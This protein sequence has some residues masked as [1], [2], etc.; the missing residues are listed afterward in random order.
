MAKPIPEATGATIY[1][2]TGAFTWKSNTAL[3]VIGVAG[4]TL[5]VTG[6]LAL[7][8]LSW[9]QIGSP[10]G[11]YALIAGGGALLAVDLVV[12]SVLAGKHFWSRFKLNE[13]LEQDKDYGRPPQLDGKGWWERQFT[14]RKA[15]EKTYT[16]REFRTYND[17][18][19]F[20]R[21]VVLHMDQKQRSIHLFLD[22]KLHE[23]YVKQLK[24]RGF[25][26]KSY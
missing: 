20:S 16:V 26:E 25:S 12:L 3:A 8:H 1:Y 18:I 22:A 13:W 15:D 21:S 19:L 11:T 2:K 5:L 17:G 14:S 24:T 4:I 9:L 23:A 7:Q 10:T 6:I